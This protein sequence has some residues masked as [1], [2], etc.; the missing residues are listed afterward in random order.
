MLRARLEF[1]KIDYIDEPDLDVRKLLPKQRGGC[2]GLLGRNVAR[3]GHDYIGFA[4]F[5]VAGPV[6][7]ADALGAMRDGGLQVHVLQ[8]HLLV[9]DDHVY[10]VLAAKA[11]IR[12]RQQAVHIRRKVNAGD[13]RTLVGHY[14]EKARILMRETVMILT[15]YR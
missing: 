10:V 14:I 4:G 9:A 1:E 8:M 3:R 13:I 11:M 15:P 6:P 12:D 7:D 5:V 2:Q